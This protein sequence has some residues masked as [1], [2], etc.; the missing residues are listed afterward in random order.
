MA[1][2]YFSET[3]KELDFEEFIKIISKK[4]DHRDEESLLD[5][6]DPLFEVANNKTFFYQVLNENLNNSL[7]GKLPNNSSYNEQSILLYDCDEFYVRMTYWPISSTN[8]IVKN[9][10]DRAF[11][12][13]NV[14]DH[15]F[16][17][18]TAGYFGNGYKTKLWEYDY[19]NVIG[20]VGEKVETSFLEETHLNKGKILFYRT[21][22]D[23]H[24]Q[25]PPSDVDSLA[26]NIILKT[27]TALFH[28]QYEFDEDAKYITSILTSSALSSTELLFSLIEQYHNSESLIH[29]EQI[30]KTNNSSSIRRKALET[31]YN[32]KG[33]KEIWK[34]G[35]E[36]INHTN[37]RYSQ[38]RFDNSK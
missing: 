14:H 15:N 34:L 12:Y 36:D 26:L 24:C 21:S 9:A 37:S 32:I 30:S 2:T 23:I 18:L 31:L 6:V 29:L 33:E 22:Q 38:F 7:N 19:N 5:C 16:P 17:L 8:P 10:Q 27:S 4:L 20:Y 28:N 25:F 3:S 13:G 35:F 11:S 1:R